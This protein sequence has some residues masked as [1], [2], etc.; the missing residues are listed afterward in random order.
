MILVTAATE[1]EMSHLLT[2]ACEED[3]PFLTLVTGVGPAKTAQHLTRFLCETTVAIDCVVN[4]GVGGGFLIPSDQELQPNILDICIADREV[5]GD[6]G[7][8]MGETLEYLPGDLVGP[9][10]FSLTGDL[11]SLAVSSLKSAGIE[12]RTG[13]FITVSSV[14]GQRARGD[15]LQKRWNGLC[16]NMEGAAAAEVCSMFELDLLELRCISNM[17]DD[18]NVSEWKLEEACSQ[19]AITTYKILK[20]LQQ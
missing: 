9:I 17:V 10:E 16:E 15:Y 7:V 8:C 19:A 1:F 3:L 13:T 14:S 4:F 12:C 6:L 20:E 11:L 18:R 5:F 2:Q